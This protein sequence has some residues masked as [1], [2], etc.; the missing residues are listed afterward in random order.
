MSRQSLNLPINIPWKQIVGMRDI[1]IHQYFGIDLDLTWE[2][3]NKD[4]PKLKKQIEA[5]NYETN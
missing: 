4:L 2:T 5:I 3:I 1:L